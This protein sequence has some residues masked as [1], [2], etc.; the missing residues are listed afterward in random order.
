MVAAQQSNLFAHILIWQ[1]QGEEPPS[2]EDVGK[3]GAAMKVP[4]YIVNAS[5]VRS[6]ALFRV[7]NQAVSCSSCSI[8][9][10]SLG[11]F[12]LVL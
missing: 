11:V 10:W 5:D 12:T 6:L 2:S 1:L 4:S 7:R 3:E 8:Y 9:F